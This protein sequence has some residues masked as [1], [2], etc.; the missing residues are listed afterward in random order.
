MSKR[1]TISE[2]I[3]RAINESGLTFLALERETGVIRQSL[4]PFA[5]GERSNSI[6][7]IDKLAAYFGLELVRESKPKAK[8]K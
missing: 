7:A 4:M 6:D 5:R 8:V 1:E 3:R 2:T